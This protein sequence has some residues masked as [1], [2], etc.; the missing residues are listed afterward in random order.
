MKKRGK[1]WTFF[2][3]PTTLRIRVIGMS[4]ILVLLLI[5][6]N[7]R[8]NDL[9]GSA[10]DPA[11][12]AQ[13]KK[14]TGKITDE[15]GVSLPGV[16]IVVKGT[17]TG[18]TTNADGT[19]SIDLSDPNSILVLSF[20]GF[21]TK[22]VSVK[23]Q[24]KLNV[25]L[26]EDVKNID[27][28]VIVAYGTQKKSHL[29][30]SVATLKSEGLDEIPVS[31][32]TQALQGKLAGVT[33]Q[34]LDPMAGEAA[35]IR[36]RGMGSISAASSP[37]VVVD[38]F[39]IPDGLSSV[40]M[41]N[42]ES[43]EVLK[44]A[45][46]AAMYGSRASGG[47]ILVTTKSG[48]T[49]KPKYNFK[50]YTGPRTA[51]KLPSILNNDQY[52]Q[53]QYD[54]AAMRM[55]DPSVDGTTATMKFNLSADADKAA[56]L[57]T[58]YY[59]DQ[60]TDWV[61]EVMRE[62][63]SIQNYQLSASGGNKDIKYF[64]SGNYNREDGIAKYSSYNKYNFL[65]KVD[66][67]L[68][69]NVTVGFNLSPTYSI[70]TKPAVGLSEV[71]RSSSW[72]PVRHNAATAALTGKIVGDYAM[73]GDFSAV[74]I[75]GIG[76]NGEIWD[77]PSAS[78][79]GSSAQ[80][81][82][83]I[84]ERTDIRTDD[85]RMQS[86]AY[87]TINLMK[88]LQF[89]TSG[90]AYVQYKEYNNKQ[91]TSASKSGNPNTLSR[92]TT[93]H[94]EMLSE[95]TFN[96]NKKVGNHEFSGLI[97]F[98]LQKTTDKNNQ[99]VG[100]GF[101]NDDMLSFNLA[102]ALIMDSPSVSGTTSFYYTEALMSYIGRITYAYKGK[103]LL[104]ASLRADGSSKFAEG[105]KWGSFPAASLGW[106]AS[107]EKFLKQYEWLTNLKL[108]A[109][110]GLTGNNNIPQYSYLN[111][112]NTSNYVTGS[113]NGTLVP[114][115]AASDAFIGNPNITWEQ[116]EEEN[117]GIDLGLFKNRINISA[118]YYTA[119]T[120]QLL[121]Q[122]PAMYITGHQ[123]FWNN[124]G[125]VNNK[126]LEIEL[127]TINVNSK[128]F[129]WKTTANFSTNKNKLLSYGDKTY[130]DNFGERSEVYRAIVGQPSIQYFGYKSDG[131]YTTFEQVAAA[132]AIKD[133]TGAAFIYTKFPPLVGGLRVVNTNGDNTIDPNDRVIL[134]TPFP[135]FT[136]GITNTF[137]YK[138]FDLSFLI[139]GVQGGK[140]IDGNM[141]YNETLRT[142]AAYLA[143]RWVSPSFPG[144]SK[145][146]F[147]KTTSGGDLCLT[148]YVMQD[149]SYAALRD[150]TLGYKVPDRI[151][152]LLRMSSVRIY[153]SASNLVYLMGSDYKGINPETRFTNGPYS[154]A[155]PLVSG[156]QRGTFPLSRSFIMG[157][158]INF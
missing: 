140:I 133:Q 35:V 107:E 125:K 132:K 48:T 82:T 56:W 130:Q 21:S 67:N 110:Y 141:N 19:Y 115:M 45:A 63:G 57:L 68:S 78:L 15:K 26:S 1:M 47:V 135:D 29:T 147:D 33:V 118:E 58:K 81:P 155:F 36:V 28:V 88:G 43:I 32:V 24:T 62:Q 149:A 5:A 44:D 97:G 34:Q 123:T 150:M 20:I 87:M 152:K 145:T 31:S 86:N 129:V 79:S 85:Y 25:V 65:A 9:A 22:E 120:I 119:N 108:R 69:K 158:D 106:R 16:S 27:E 109:S 93:L 122:Q 51:L 138:G 151:S 77:I 11:M 89:K 142:T 53:L 74:N 6:P 37:L 54:E 95:N 148:D 18:V 40:S 46:S 131:V 153:C 38:G 42:V 98:T 139:Q 137:S 144:D 80:N 101:P 30:G 2:I 75:S 76:L 143:N 146:T 70:Q 14:V 71:S 72:L 114:G 8:A 41:G 90:G 12:A 73:A 13:Q 117:F 84:N 121:L 60:P 111:A 50:M 52:V 92:Q 17:T 83:S 124:I 99:I 104:S 55:Q 136:Y 112:L 102:S 64:I 61:K 126:G 94:S 103:Y 23:N 91:K 49:A 59:L 100:T 96:Y 113:G 156:Y 154:S 39:P 3:S 134:G 4:T 10:P 7:V 127:S 157:I 116:T 105:H 128:G 66:I